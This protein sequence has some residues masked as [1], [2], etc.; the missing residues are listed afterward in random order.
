MPTNLDPQLESMQRDR[1]ELLSAY[2]DG[3]VTADERRQVETWL[4]DDPATQQLHRRLTSLHRAFQAMP[5]P[6]PAQHVDL[7]VAHVLK[8]VDRRPRLQ[9]L[10]GGGLV[11]AAAAAVAI[12]TQLA[13]GGSFS[14]EF[15]R[16]PSASNGSLTAVQPSANGMNNA[17]L[18]VALDEPAYIPMKDAVASDQ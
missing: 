11:A 4:K 3:E 14:P 18:M 1:F 17:V 13:G 8:R 9:L 12:V 10:A 5:A 6:V 7:V 2:L 15:A 16:Q